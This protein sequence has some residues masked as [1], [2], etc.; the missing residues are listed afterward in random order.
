MDV[1]D[2][3]YRFPA[4]KAFVKA[5]TQAGFKHSVDFNGAEQEGVGFFQVTQT[6]Q[7]RRANSAYSFLDE[8]LER[9]N[10]TVITHAHVTRVIFEGKRAIGVEFARGSTRKAA[11]ASPREELSANKDVILSAGVINSP[12]ILKLSGV[13]PKE[14]LELHGIPV[15]HHLPGVGENLQDH[16]DVIIRCLDKSGTSLTTGLKLSTLKFWYKVFTQ[17]NFMFIPTDSGG[18]IRSSPEEPIPDLQLQFAA[19][20]MLPHGSGLTTPMRPGFVLHVCHLRPHSRGQVRLVSK[21]P[22][23][24]PLITANYFEHEKELDALVKGVR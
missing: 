22:F 2:T 20:R 8:A 19:I 15:V 5:A 11:A 21:N 10:L 4:S 9:P 18:F 14:E 1:V 3:N 16:P 17:K 24:D 7:G 13:G 23:A 6:P 12:H